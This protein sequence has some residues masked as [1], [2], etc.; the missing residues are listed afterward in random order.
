MKDMNEALRDKQVFI[1]TGTLTAGC[2]I[3][4]P[5]DH[6]VSCFINQSTDPMQFVQGLY[7]V[8][9]FKT[10]HMIIP[11]FTLENLQPIYQCVP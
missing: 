3:Q 1:Y 11:D 7:R 6:H 8:R 10:M 2:D 4:Q 5:F 9:N